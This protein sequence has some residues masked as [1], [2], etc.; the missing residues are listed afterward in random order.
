MSF[1]HTL[2]GVV[3]LSAIGTLAAN[4]VLPPPPLIVINSLQYDNGMITQDRTVN[5][6]A[7]VVF[8]EWRAEIVDVR[9]GE[10]VPEC[11]GQGTWNYA[12][13]RKVARM[14]LAR[15]TGNDDC[16]ASALTSPEGY[17]PRAT[18]TW[19]ENQVVG[20]G[21]VFHSGEGKIK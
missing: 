19:G 12:S 1:T 6:D 17:F 13:G 9:S 20:K 21:A 16:A 7:E 15:W 2:V 8:M 4:L 14:T 3:A 10:P 5:S 11:Q 18:Y